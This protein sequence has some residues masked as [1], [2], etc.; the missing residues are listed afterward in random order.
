MWLP[1]LIL[2][3]LAGTV[4]L[5]AGTL[6][7]GGPC[8]RFQAGPR[9]TGCN[10]QPLSRS[11]GTFINGIITCQEVRKKIV[12]NSYL[13]FDCARLTTIPRR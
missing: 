10:E 9:Q 6:A 12:V 8:F 3:V 4:G 1:L 11:L 5:L 13:N 7:N 2:H